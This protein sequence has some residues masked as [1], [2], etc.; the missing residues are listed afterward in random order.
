M[1]LV[2]NHHRAEAAATF[3]E[4]ARAPHGGNH[5]LSL[6]YITLLC[7]TFK[8]AHGIHTSP[9]YARIHT[10][11]HAH[12][13]PPAP[14]AV[15]VNKSHCDIPCVWTCIQHVKNAS[16]PATAA[17]AATELA[18]RLKQALRMGLDTERK[19][20]VSMSL[21]QALPQETLSLCNEALDD[22][23]TNETAVDLHQLHGFPYPEE[24][25]E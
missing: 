8:H 2:R 6:T 25:K 23:K 24:Q 13:T 4:D 9:Q 19:L 17:A 18:E 12:I 11:P 22:V 15:N 3:A 1:S 7:S 21:L 20:Q 5:F 10:Q 14:S 16:T